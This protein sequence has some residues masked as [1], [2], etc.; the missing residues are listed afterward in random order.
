[1]KWRVPI[2]ALLVLACAV[3]LGGTAPGQASAPVTDYSGTL[4]GVAYK[5]RV[6]APWNGTLLVFAHPHQTAGPQPWPAPQVPG[7]EQQ[8]LNMGYALAGSAFGDSTKEGVQRTHQL[9]G[10]FRDAVANPSRTIVWGNSFGA[11]IALKLIEKY[12]GIYDG[13]IANCAPAAGQVENMDSALAFSL[14][15]DAAIGWREDLWGPVEDVRDDLAVPDVLPHV[16]WPTDED[17]RPA[18]WQFIRL[19]MH[20]TDAAFWTADPGSGG[21]KFYQLYM[22]KA[23]VLRAAAEREAGGP[24]AENI[25]MQYTVDADEATLATL[26]L[27]RAW[28]DQ[29]LAE[30]NARATIVADRAARRH[31]DQ[32]G[33]PT[34]RLPNPVLTMH[35]VNDG[36]AFVTTENYYKALVASQGAGDLLLQTYVNGPGHC[37]FTPVEYTNA[38]SAMN[39]WLDTNVRPAP[40]SPLFTSPRFTPAFAP[41]SWIF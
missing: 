4:D 18:A 3:L 1:M 41:G 11:G 33:A 2:V 39:S 9:T 35:L 21:W 29:K 23:T 40:S 20:L 32:W 15:Y 6:P 16:P 38:L 12:P 36:M 28:V 10:F 30:M 8:L 17:P 31:L 5:I 14:A 37:A 27:T 22:W 26:G 25:G 34:G 13:A 24:V 19:V 7:F